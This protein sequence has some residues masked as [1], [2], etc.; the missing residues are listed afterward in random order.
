MGEVAHEAAIILVFVG[1]SA[2]LVRACGSRF[3]LS[4]SSECANEVTTRLSSLL[5]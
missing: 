1:L 5:G 3:F 4:A 2:A